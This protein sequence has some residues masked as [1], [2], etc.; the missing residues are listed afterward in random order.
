VINAFEN[1]VITR[2]KKIL[3]YLLI[4]RTLAERFIARSAVKALQMQ[5]FVVSD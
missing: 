1:E 4:A 2:S 3:I 5:Y